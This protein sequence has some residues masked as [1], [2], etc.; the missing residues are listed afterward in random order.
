[1]DAASERH[2]TAAGEVQINL[3]GICEGRK[4][5]QGDWYTDW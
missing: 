5:K 2:Y 4:A 1:V 3:G